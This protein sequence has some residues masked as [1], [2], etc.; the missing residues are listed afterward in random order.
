MALVIPIMST[1][2]LPSITALIILASPPIVI[3]TYAGFTSVS[4]EVIESA[5][6]MGMSKWQIFFRVKLPLASGVI[7]NG[8]KI[9]SIEVIATST[10]AAFIGGGGLG[11]YIISGVNMMDTSLILIGT[12]PLCILILLTELLLDLTSKFICRY[13]DVNL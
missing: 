7:T 10:I 3:N 5:N 9:S 13:K 6:A 1:G 2:F 12:I 11:E 8:C 4:K